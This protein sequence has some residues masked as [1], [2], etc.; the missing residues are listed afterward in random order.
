MIAA[1]KTNGEIFCA[2][3]MCF[4]SF[5]SL[6]VFLFYKQHFD[7]YEYIVFVQ[8]FIHAPFSIALHTKRACGDPCYRGKGLIIRRLD[9]SFI[10]VASSLLCFGLSHC[11]LYGIF[12]TFINV[13]YICK[14]WKFKGRIQTPPISGVAVCIAIYLFGLV[15]NERIH[16]FLCACLLST[17]LYI[18]TYFDVIG[19]SI[20]HVLS[21]FLQY[22]FM[23]HLVHE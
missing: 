21:A 4:P 11:I 8:C 23:W 15:I 7:A 13:F 10:H 14:I 2:I 9:Y 22:V 5:V 18:C 16:S 20:M 3:T 12:G 17:L 1:P 19:Y 6:L